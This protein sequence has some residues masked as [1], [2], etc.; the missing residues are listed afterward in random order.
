MK[1]KRFQRLP[2]MLLGLALLAAAMPFAASAQT[3]G[4]PASDAPAP[5]RITRVPATSERDLQNA[6]ELRSELESLL[7]TLEKTPGATEGQFDMIRRRISGYDRQIEQLQGQNGQNEV[8][9]GDTADSG[10][11]TLTLKGNF[12]GRGVFVFEGRTI[13][14]RHESGNEPANVT[15]DGTPWDD[16]KKPFAL[17]FTPDFAKAVIEEQSRQLTTRHVNVSLIPGRDKFELAV[18]SVGSAE[19]SV[20]I[21]AKNRKPG[22]PRRSVGPLG[23]STRTE[24]TDGE[25]HPG[26]PVTRPVIAPL[27]DLVRGAQVEVRGMV[28]RKA[29]FRIEDANLLYQNYAADPEKPS[30]SAPALFDGKFAYDVTVNGKAWNNLSIPV[31]VGA[32]IAPGRGAQIIF[33]AEDCGISFSEYDKTLEVIITNRT[34][35]PAP[36]QFIVWIEGSARPDPA[37]RSPNMQPDNGRG[38][39]GDSRN[40]RPQS[41]RRQETKAKTSSVAASE[42]QTG[43]KSVSI[44]PRDAIPSGLKASRGGDLHYN[45]YSDTIYYK[46]DGSKG[47]ELEYGLDGCADL[48]KQEGLDPALHFIGGY[49]MNNDHGGDLVAWRFVETDSGRS[50]EVGYHESGKLDKWRVIG[51]LGVPEGVNWN[52]YCGN[53]TGHAWLNSILWHSPGSGM[54]GYWADGKGVDSWVSIPGEYKG[55]EWKVLGL[56]RF[57][58]ATEARASVLFQYGDNTI[59]HVTTDGKFTELGRLDDGLKI[60]ALGNFSNKGYTDLILFNS[61][62]NQVGMWESGRSRNWKS[63]GFVDAGTVIEGAGDYDS[64]GVIDLLAR[65]ADGTMGCY[66]KGDLNK[67]KSFG[68]KKDPSWIVIP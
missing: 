25:A 60:V 6:L 63:L 32:G 4:T 40:D 7:R 20:R 3:G 62:L 46:P 38:G 35:E 13:Q 33:R 44:D 2:G 22:Q 58:G 37:F 15:I 68:Y 11:I 53:L 19:H 61:K 67:F 45:G 59:G 31:G 50:I 1:Q 41:G 65:K 5:R 42:T 21:A 48:E 57:Y 23:S 17:S 39:M 54:L 8:S 64:D 47:P 18:S 30:G 26:Y 34:G 16:L 51:V 56:G 27:P 28:D 24:P 43:T 10:E 55:P 29:G 66:L 12:D 52:L 9:R 14:Y 36:F 49:D